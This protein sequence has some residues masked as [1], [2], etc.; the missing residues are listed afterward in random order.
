[1]T[2]KPQNENEN[3]ITSLLRPFLNSIPKLPNTKDEENL[4]NTA[5]E[6]LQKLPPEIQKRISQNP[7]IAMAIAKIVLG[8]GGYGDVILWV[9]RWLFEHSSLEIVLLD[10]G[11]EEGEVDKVKFGLRNAL[12]TKAKL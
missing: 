11:G 12:K 7:E 8:G 3:T 4:C 5:W 10:G 6:I 2:P 1:M 9:A